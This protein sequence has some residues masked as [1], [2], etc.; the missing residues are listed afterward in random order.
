MIAKREREEKK[1]W[2]RN[3]NNE[4]KEKACTRERERQRDRETDRQRDRKKILQIVT[5][6]RSYLSLT[7]KLPFSLSLFTL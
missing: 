7:I 4:G 5:S 2:K 3:D 6:L 1:T